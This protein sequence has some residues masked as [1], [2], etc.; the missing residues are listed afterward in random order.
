MKIKRV[1]YA[2][3]F[4]RNARDLTL[5]PG[6][7]LFMRRGLVRWFP[8]SDCVLTRISDHRR[9]VRV[10]CLKNPL[11]GVVWIRV[12]STKTGDEEVEVHE[13]V[14]ANNQEVIEAQ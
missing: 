13:G 11:N 10:Y 5:L 1:K 12:R 6:K 7:F 9:G 2:T 4:P 14:R 3:F 8:P